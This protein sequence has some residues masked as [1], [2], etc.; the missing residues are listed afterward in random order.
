LW[1][2]EG[3]ERWRER[4]LEGWYDREVPK[5]NAALGAGDIQIFFRRVAAHHAGEYLPNEHLPKDL[6]MCVGHFERAGLIRQLR[7]W[8]KPINKQECPHSKIFIRDS[9][10]FHALRQVWTMADVRADA[11]LH[12][13]SWEGFCIENLISAAGGR[14]EAFHFRASM[15][16]PGEQDEVDL[17]LKF[18][19]TLVVVE[20]K[21]G[22]GSLSRG[23]YRICEELK[24]AHR[25][26]IRDVE[27]Y[28]REDV[29]HIPLGVA[30]QL[31]REIAIEEGHHT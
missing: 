2:E 20:C 27:S 6:R 29:A 17:I 3:S 21:A 31:V 25:I 30:V 13:D 10:L 18:G 1:D 16:P 19:G 11:R 14:A 28:V 22:D 8:P 26:A 4:Y 12:G 15:A 5:L 23:F 9:G 24:P 7:P